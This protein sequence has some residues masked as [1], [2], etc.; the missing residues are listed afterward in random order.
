MKQC[1]YAFYSNK[2]E[3]IVIQSQNSGGIH[4][5]CSQM[6]QYLRPKIFAF[7]PS[8]QKD[9]DLNYEYLLDK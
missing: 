9:T 7:L 1:L 8:S 3:I 4:S 6:T 2:Y 5:L